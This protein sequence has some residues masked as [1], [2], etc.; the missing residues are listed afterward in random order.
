M[1]SYSV[2]NFKQDLYSSELLSKI[3]NTDSTCDE[4]NCKTEAKNY[5]SSNIPDISVI[6]SQN[7]CAHCGCEVYEADRYFLFFLIFTKF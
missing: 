3:S 2:T 4:T 5:I 7:L 1:D 6:N